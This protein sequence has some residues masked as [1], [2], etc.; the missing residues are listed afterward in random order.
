MPDEFAKNGVPPLKMLSNLVVMRRKAI[1]EDFMFIQSAIN[2]DNTPD[3]NDFM[4]K[5][6]KRSWA[7]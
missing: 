3:F 2:D 5:T 6:S 7:K 1:N 4:Y